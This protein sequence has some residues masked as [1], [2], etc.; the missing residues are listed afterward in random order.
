MANSPLELEKAEQSLIRGIN[1]ILK[2]AGL[3]VEADVAADKN[4]ACPYRLLELAF[5]CRDKGGFDPLKDITEKY[6][7]NGRLVLQWLPPRQDGFG[8]SMRA[9]DPYTGEDREYFSTAIYRRDEFDRNVRKKKQERGQKISPLH[10]CPDLDKGRVIP[11]WRHTA[12]KIWKR[13]AQAALQARKEKKSLPLNDFI[14]LEAGLNSIWVSSEAR[15]R[16]HFERVDSKNPLLAIENK[17]KVLIDWKAESLGRL[18]IPHASHEKRLCPFQTPESKRT[19]LNLQ[20]SAGAEFGDEGKIK[21]GD[22]TLSVAVGMI[23]YPSHTDGPRLMM[24]GKNMKQAETGIKGK[25][26]SL[27]PGI[28]EG[29]AADNIAVLTDCPSFCHSE[30]ANGRNR[31]KLGLNAL[32]VIMPFKGYTYEDGIV[33]SQSLAERFHLPKSE[34]SC[35]KVLKNVVI[36]KEDAQKA[37]GIEKSS[38]LTAQSLNDFFQRYYDECLKKPR[39]FVY[40]DAIPWFRTLKLR[41]FL[42]GKKASAKEFPGKNGSIRDRTEEYRPREIYSHHAPGA[43]TDREQVVITTSFVEKGQSNKE[44]YYLSDIHITWKFRVDRPMALGDKIT[45]RSGN[46]GVV[47]QIVPDERMPQIHFSSGTVPAE[48]IISPSSVMGRMNLGQIWEMTH[49][50]LIKHSALLKEESHANIPIN[51]ELDPEEYS[52]DRI[53]RLLKKTGAD[54]RGAF[55]VTY[56]GA[57]GQERETR[58][59]AGWQYFC[60]LHHHAWKKLQGRGKDAPYEPATG[61]PLR[62]GSRTGQR[63]GEMENWTLLNHGAKEILLE[64]R[65]LHTGDSQ[66]T[67]ELL[68]KILRSLGIDLAGEKTSDKPPLRFTKLKSDENLK[69][70]SLQDLSALDLDTEPIDRAYSVYAQAP[71]QK[72]PGSQRLSCRELLEQFPGQRKEEAVQASDEENAPVDKEKNSWRKKLLRD[73]QEALKS[74]A[75]FDEEGDLRVEIELLSLYRKELNGSLVRFGLETRAMQKLEAFRDYRQFLITLLS[76]KT[77]IPRRYLAGRRYDHSGRAVIV[78]EP[79]LA[80]HQVYLPVAMLTELLEGYG[81]G[82]VKYLPEELK[83]TSHLRATVN[84]RPNAEKEEESRALAKRLD[85]HLASDRGKLWGF[86]IRQPS[87]HRH[88]VQAFQ[89]RCWEHPVIGFPPLVTAGFNAD[90]DG[91][92]MAVFLP[93]YPYASAK[94]LSRYSIVDNPGLNGNGGS[95]FAAELDLALG[96]WKLPEKRRKKWYDLIGESVPQELEALKDYL[97]KLLKVMGKMGFDSRSETLRELQEEVCEW[98]SGAA[99][100]TPVEFACLCEELKKNE[101]LEQ[102][103]KIGQGQSEKEAENAIKDLLDGKHEDYGLALL[104]KAKAKGKY[105]NVRQMVWAI[106]AVT[107]MTDEDITTA[108]NPQTEED[109]FIRGNFWEGLGDEELFQYSY[110]SRFGMAQKKLAVAPAG[111]LTRQLA[112]G[113]FEVTV[114]KDSQPSAHDASETTADGS[115]QPQS[116]ETAESPVNDA[117]QAQSSETAEEKE[118]RPSKEA[119]QGLWISC[120]NGQL[121]ISTSEEGEKLP[122]PKLDASDRSIAKDLDRAAWGRVPVGMERCLDSHDLKYLEQ[123]WIEEK[124][125]PLA[126]DLKKHLRDHNHALVLRT[127]LFSPGRPQGKIDPLCYGADVAQKPFDK[128]QPVEAGFAAGLVAAQAIGERGTQLAMKRFHDVAGSKRGTQD[129]TVTAPQPPKAA[130]AGKNVRKTGSAIQTMKRVL[131]FGKSADDLEKLRKLF[132]E[133]LADPQEPRRANPELPQAL[134]HYEV[135][136]AGAD[137]DRSLEEQAQRSEGRYLSALAHERIA[138][139]LTFAPQADPSGQDHNEAVNTA[140]MERTDDLKTIKSEMLWKAGEKS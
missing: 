20:L 69:S 3:S 108:E 85:T 138:P 121:H 38:E 58:A 107:K 21:P 32:T 7:D 140:L 11:A 64:M 122:L 98:S 115:P 77:G 28:Y 75:M 126:E 99:T 84:D 68:R 110:P 92:T 116:P 112:E 76:H 62:C 63:L 6:G 133:I 43:I 104:L 16:A 18:R 81:S 91:D 125:E 66:R 55:K 33:I 95:A 19:G 100:M 54:E 29:H 30:T 56:A 117:Q 97:P 25:E 70:V 128:P 40:G 127:P 47:T 74:N 79:S 59:F 73:V 109:V 94:Y 65:R 5:V 26:G 136:I 120:A 8:C 130:Q 35:H 89:I 106:G 87:L 90:F 44:K 118:P 82:Y 37:L 67:R 96:W 41:R 31:L 23:P 45:G 139:L 105:K 22:Q 119:E 42:S 101:K 4:D 48:L 9:P 83:N 2:E 78:P 39:N 27:V 123:F 113:L 131:V 14:R 103:K 17:R 34:F 60:R 72:D 12:Q 57:D 86:V 10:L 137:G 114:G 53:R 111:Y 135:A 24:G 61:Q 102:A 49:S 124:E 46:K 51:D 80:P 1:D 36:L 52:C 129:T 50:V 71:S 132:T 88:S 134:I 93:P 15:D 13:F